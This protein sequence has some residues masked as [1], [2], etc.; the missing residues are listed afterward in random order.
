[1]RKRNNQKFVVKKERRFTVNVSISFIL[2]L[3]AIAFVFV[4]V[5][6]IVGYQ[7]IVFYLHKQ[8]K[9]ESLFFT[10][11]VS[12]TLLLFLVGFG[13]SFNLEYIYLKIPI[14]LFVIYLIYVGFDYLGIG[15]IFNTH[16][17]LLF[18][19]IYESNSKK[20]MLFFAYNLYIFGI[21]WLI[22]LPFMSET[23]D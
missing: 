13:Y 19:H 4:F 11:L 1:M 21:A 7:H 18:Y 16:F 2:K 8:D 20:G 3:V 6:L 14:F 9:Y 5:F 12:M 17:N 23:N 15:I 10:L 22:H